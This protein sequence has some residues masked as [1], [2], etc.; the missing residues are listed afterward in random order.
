M[1]AR[2][3]LVDDFTR[4]IRKCIFYDRNTRLIDK[5]ESMIGQVNLIGKI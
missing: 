4:Y 3:K 2:L 5:F 1:V